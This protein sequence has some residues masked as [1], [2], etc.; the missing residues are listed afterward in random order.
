M[1]KFILFFLFA[2]IGLHAM[3]PDDVAL[4]GGEAKRPRTTLQEQQGAL[5]VRT[6]TRSIQ[7]YYMLSP[8]GT[9]R[10]IRNP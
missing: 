9:N 8:V 1:Q 10:L 4:V 6:P 5:E 7:T 3:Q 2:V